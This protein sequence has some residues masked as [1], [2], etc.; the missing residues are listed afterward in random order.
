MI[1]YVKGSVYSL[2]VSFEYSKVKV[3]K[4]VAIGN[5]QQK[6]RM[7]QQHISHNVFLIGDGVE[8]RSVTCFILKNKMK[9]KQIQKTTIDLFDPF[10]LWKN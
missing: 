10:I 3:I 6:S 9:R 5:L 1:L 2:L 4:A 7:I 8:E